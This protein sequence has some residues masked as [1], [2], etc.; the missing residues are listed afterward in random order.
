MHPS[1]KRPATR[2][3]PTIKPERE[4]SALCGGCLVGGI[5]EAG[6]GPLAGPVVAACVVWDLEGRRPAGLGDSKQLTAARRERLHR[7]IVRQALGWG[8][9]IATP[10]EIDLLNVLEATR[11]AAQRA[12]A[13]CQDML[14]ERRIGALVTDYLDIPALALP[15]LPLVKGDCKSASVA[16]ASILAKVT[17]DR[18]MNAY[19]DEFPMYGWDRNRGY[20]TPDHYAALAAHGPSSLHRLSFNGVGFFDV[21]LRRSATY[22]RLAE[23]L[24]AAPVCAETLAGLH[25]EIAASA[26]NLPPA[27]YEALL[28]ELH[29]RRDR[30]D[31]PADD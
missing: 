29:A 7:Q 2:S 16:A 25:E 24:G 5:D 6:R 10:G 1:K 4:F 20:P 9:G 31:Q 18:L 8:V 22:A 30:I 14:G 12:F 15:T 21:E 19:H 23:Q 13:A 28:R 26:A 3:R 27:D 17:R 11:L